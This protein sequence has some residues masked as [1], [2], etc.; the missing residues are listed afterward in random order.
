MTN[1]TL[2]DFRKIVIAGFLSFFCWGATSAQASVASA[3]I[4]V[5]YF[6]QVPAAEF[7]S[8]IKPVF[9]ANSR[10][11]KNCELINLTPYSATGEVEQKLITE[12]I[13]SLPSE[14]SF[15]FFDFNTR[16]T[17]QNKKWIEAL[18]K[19][20]AEGLLVV[21]TAGVPIAPESSGP[22]SRTVLGQVHGSFIVGELTDRDRLTPSGFY[23]PEMLTALR[24]PKDLL[25]QGYVPL[26]FA[27][28]LAENWNKRS[29]QEWSE[30]FKQKKIKS[31]KIWLSLNDLF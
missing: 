23:G 14:I 17:E 24:G 22:L 19:K 16:A 30:H 28:T 31:R 3:K 20:S 11:C 18:N 29:P 10:R 26:I 12:K 2:I 8:K 5:G 9:E 1:S 21:G 7:D 13:E 4:K 25:G 6:G 15:V 27:A